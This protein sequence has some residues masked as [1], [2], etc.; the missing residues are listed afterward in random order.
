MIEIK[1]VK[2]SDI[3]S[4]EEFIR[5]SNNGTIF[6][7][8]N[9]LAYHPSE[10]FNFHHLAF[11]KN[12]KMIACLPAAIDAD[13]NFK[14]PIGASYGSL[15]TNNCTF[16]EYEEIVDSLIKYAKVKLYK[17]ITL[18]P[19]PIIYLKHQNQL[20]QFIL[21]YKNFTVLYHLITNAVDLHSI[22]SDVPLNSLTSMHKRAVKKSINEGVTTEFTD[23]LIS[24]YKLLLKNKRKF[25]ATPTHSL[26]EIKFLY[27]HFPDKIKLLSA[28]SKEGEIIAS[29]LLFCTNNQTVLA[30]YICHDYEYQ[31]LRAVNR[32]LYESII[33]AIKNN[34][35]WFDL[36]VSMD[37]KSKNVMEPSRSLIS[38]K[39]GIGTRGFLRTTYFLKL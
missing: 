31:H 22:D 28:K 4:W 8:L 24:F 3:P 2:K 36:G 5:N 15:V 6:H 12:Q 26:K 23:D 17:S 11:Y 18:T 37:T 33:W 32:L 38:F 1:K 21:E 16:S 34:Y 30:F 14:S 27:K 13:N 19:P 35:R 29:I 9:F 10:K 7:S 20:E 25:N 39:E